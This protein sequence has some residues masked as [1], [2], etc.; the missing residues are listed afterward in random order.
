[1]REG[2]WSSPRG[3]P[4]FIIRFAILRISGSDWR[5]IQSMKMLFTQ[6]KEWNSSFRYLLWIPRRIQNMRTFL[7]QIFKWTELRNVSQ[8]KYLLYRN[9]E[10]SR[11]SL[12]S[13]TILKHLTSNS[14]WHD[15]KWSAFWGTRKEHHYSA[16]RCFLS[17]YVPGSCSPTLNSSSETFQKITN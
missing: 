4:E 16:I 3:S 15:S 12:L 1:M 11:I 14:Y 5:G 2:K 7:R 9:F 10:F 6:I 13:L 8:H 17:L